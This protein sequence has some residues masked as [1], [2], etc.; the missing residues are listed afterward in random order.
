MRIFF[1]IG[2]ALLL[3]AFFAGAAEIASHVVSGQ[4]SFTLSAREVWYTLAP[5]SLIV[6]EIKAGNV[7]PPFLSGTVLPF[8]LSF[9]AWAL[10]GLPGGILAWRFHPKRSPEK[11]NDPDEDLFLLDRLAAQAREEGYVDDDPGIDLS[12]PPQDERN[13]E[14]E[15]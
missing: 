7:L 6:F 1:L 10:F 12:L 8:L 11:H 3:A 9:P 2:L 14:K 15:P 4:S 13:E 5:G